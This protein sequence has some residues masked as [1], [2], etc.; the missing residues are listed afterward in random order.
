MNK[1][2]LYTGNQ[3]FEIKEVKPKVPGEG[4]V[5]IKV[6]HCGICGTDLHIFHGKMD[7]RVSIPQPIGHEMSGIITE[8]GDEV[9]GLTVG[10][11]VVVRPLDWC[12]ECPACKNG[13]THICQKLKFLGID[14]P[15]AFQ[16]H[17]SVPARVVHKIPDSI[18]MDIAA[19]IE[20]LAVACHDLRIAE[21]KS[22]EYAVVLG[23]GPIGMLIAM[24][25]RH[26]GLRVLLSEIN[27]VRLALAAEIGIDTINPKEQDLVKTVWK[28]TGNA[29]ADIV[30]EAT[31][32]QAAASVMTELPRCR[33]RIVTVGIFS[34]PPQ[35]DLFKFFWR[36]LQLRGARVYEEA[37]YETAI[38]M[39]AQ[40]TLPLDKL[41]TRVYPLEQIQQAFESL[42]NNANAMKVL[43]QCSK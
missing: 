14:T 8:I 16:S 10:D 18:P 39:A 42:E 26:Q 24:T 35:I 28:N 19:L 37:D 4:Q 13:F 30:F 1:A 40:N 12:G 27:P 38:E 21:A 20:P 33:G 36:E 25:A 9:D 34:Q 2:A 5:R 41:I 7:A 3:N 15:G 43:V 31:A 6:S 22:G 23:G 32:T 17:W 29:G 11:R